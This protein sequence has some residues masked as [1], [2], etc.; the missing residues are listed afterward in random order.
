MDGV[1]FVLNPALSFR[2]D[3]FDVSNNFYHDQPFFTNTKF[4]FRFSCRNLTLPQKLAV[5]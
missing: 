5:I 2:R 3:K 1:P 4:L